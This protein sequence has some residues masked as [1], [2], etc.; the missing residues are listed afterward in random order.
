MTPAEERIGRIKRESSFGDLVRVK[1]D[2][3]TGF[4]SLCTVEPVR[5]GVV[6][7]DLVVVVL[8]ISPCIAVHTPWAREERKNV[9]SIQGDTAL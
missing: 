9:R 7:L 2:R 6:S 1:E 3:S 5:Y 4:P 8:F